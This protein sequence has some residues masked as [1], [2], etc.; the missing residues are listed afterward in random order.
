MEE[1][2]TMS[3]KTPDGYVEVEVSKEVYDFDNE[4]RNKF[5]R[6]SKQMRDHNYSLDAIVY[7]GSEFGFYE[8]YPCEEI[9][10]RLEEQKLVQKC[11]I[12]LKKLTPIQQRRFMMYA[13][14]DYTYEQ[15]ADKEGVGL[16]T[17]YESV[18]SAL[19]KIR[20]SL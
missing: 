14:E 16:K 4:N 13:L 3:V 17:V 11:L 20:K 18:Q 7:E 19:K 9:E 12:A 1:K 6:I 10:E 5:G 15:I 2:Y 8:T